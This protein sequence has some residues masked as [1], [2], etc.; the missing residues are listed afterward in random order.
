MPKVKFHNATLNATVMILFQPTFSWMFPV[1]SQMLPARI[2]IFENWNLNLLFN[3]GLMGGKNSKCHS[4][5]LV[6]TS[7]PYDGF[8][9]ACSVQTHFGDIQCTF[10]QMTC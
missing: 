1:F 6:G 8:L 10:L 7:K 9:W 2:L 3:M 5:R 4:Y